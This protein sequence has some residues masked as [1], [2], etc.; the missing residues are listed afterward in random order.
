MQNSYF[1]GRALLNSVAAV[2]LLTIVTLWVL[3]QFRDQWEHG[4]R[5]WLFDEDQVPCCNVARWDRLCSTTSPPCRFAVLLSR[6]ACG[7]V[8]SAFP[9]H[10][11]EQKH[12]ADVVVNMLSSRIFVFTLV[13]ASTVMFTLTHTVLDVVVLRGDVASSGAA[14]ACEGNCPAGLYTMPCAA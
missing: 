9:Q 11:P 4:L 12:F 7:G 10:Q 6:C 8:S 5:D 13:N 1:D 3:K 2:V 14:V